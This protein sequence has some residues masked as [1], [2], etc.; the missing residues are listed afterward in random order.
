MD[1]P[2]VDTTPPVQ[3]ASSSRA[4]AAPTPKSSTTRGE[5]PTTDNAGDTDTDLRIY[6]PATFEDVM[7]G[8]PVI[9]PGGTFNHA[10]FW[11]RNMQA[12]LENAEELIKQLSRGIGNV[13]RESLAD[14]KAQ[15]DVLRNSYLAA[16]R[17]HLTHTDVTRERIQSFRHEV[18]LAS[19][20]LAAEV[21]YYLGCC[22]EDRELRGRA[23]VPFKQAA[24][25]KVNNELNNCVSVGTS[26]AYIKKQLDQYRKEMDQAINLVIREFGKGFPPSAGTVTEKAS[27]RTAKDPLD[28]DSSD[29]SESDD[30]PR[31]GGGGE[32]GSG[33]RP[34]GSPHP[35]S[36]LSSEPKAPDK[37]DVPLDKAITR[38]LKFIAMIPAN[39]VLKLPTF[40]GKGFAKFRSW[41]RSMD[42]YFL[43]S[44]SAFPT[45]ESRIS[46][47]GL[48]LTGAAQKWHQER[49]R[50]MREQRVKNQWEVYRKSLKQKFIHPAQAAQDL[51]KM[52]KLKYNG[53]IG[54]YLMGLEHLNF[55]V[56]ASG[57]PFQQL[58]MSSIPWKI[59]EMVF[60]RRG[61]IPEDD[62][63]FVDAVEKAG[64]AHEYKVAISPG[65]RER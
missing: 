2:A 23:V 27:R 11:L 10:P 48:H 12:R 29:D 53:D 60:N 16:I 45:D 39:N 43:T 6:Q 3:Q 47:M 62:K 35:T 8:Q 1:T 15:Y 55:T 33:R 25:R 38:A 20:S 28:S 36:A 7:A 46:W 58:I 21:W 57:V 19:D 37:P 9:P 64:R 40:N 63:D 24:S 30:F 56:E 49:L 22:T 41:W 65:L 31:R 54:K 61:E 42:S 17:M 34:R 51:A 50:I 4:T 44:H 59:M 14:A 32:G 13:Y 52:K 5:N 26:D 18:I